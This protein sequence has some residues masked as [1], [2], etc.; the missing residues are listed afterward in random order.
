[1][2][3]ANNIANIGSWKLWGLMDLSVHARHWALIECSGHIKSLSAQGAAFVCL[4]VCFILSQTGK[5]IN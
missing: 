5:N 2:Q 1:M 4:F 3:R